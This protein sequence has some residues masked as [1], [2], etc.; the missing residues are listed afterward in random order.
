MESEIQAQY[1]F[2]IQW[3]E[4]K[5]EIFIELV[6]LP[7]LM[8]QVGPK[9]MYAKKR[10]EEWRVQIEVNLSHERDVHTKCE[11]TGKSLGGSDCVLPMQGDAGF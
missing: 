8:Y 5:M 11:N 6:L 1:K 3:I 7:F 10:R 4:I 2:K 9:N